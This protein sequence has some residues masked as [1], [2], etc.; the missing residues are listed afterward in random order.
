[1][2]VNIGPTDNIVCRTLLRID[3]E[4]KQVAPNLTF[5]YD[6]AITPDELLQIA[7]TNICQ[8]SKPHIAN[9]P[10][11]LMHAALVL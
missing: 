11:R 1:M 5:M 10:V 9:Y 2:H 7:T 4:L 8:C 6:P 3:A